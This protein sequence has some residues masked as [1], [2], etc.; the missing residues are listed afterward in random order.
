MPTYEDKYEEM[1]NKYSDN[2]AKVAP[3]DGDNGV[4]RGENPDKI[5]GMRIVIDPGENESFEFVIDG[6]D[7]PILKETSERYAPQL[8]DPELSPKERNSI[9]TAIYHEVYA[10][11]QQA[12][13]IKK[14]VSQ[15]MTRPNFVPNTATIEHETISDLPEHKAVSVQFDFEPCMRGPGGKPFPGGVNTASYDDVLIHG[16]QLVLIGNNKSGMY[17]PPYSEDEPLRASLIIEGLDNPVYAFTTSILFP[18]G[19]KVFC[20]MLLDRDLE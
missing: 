17:V 9:V 10:R 5:S 13:N 6:K 7:D 1:L 16:D 2:I 3:H 12:N 8:A 15:P 4:P 20:L 14:Q 18:Y 11:K 19:N